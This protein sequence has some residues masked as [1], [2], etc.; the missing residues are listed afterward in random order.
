MAEGPIILRDYSTQ[1]NSHITRPQCDPPAAQRGVYT[2]AHMPDR[3][4]GGS[5]SFKITLRVTH[6]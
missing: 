3:A 6:S 5:S 4:L 1:H 2:A